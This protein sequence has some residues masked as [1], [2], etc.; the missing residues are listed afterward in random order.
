MREFYLHTER[1][2][3]GHGK[4]N[5]SVVMI[6]FPVVYCILVT[7]FILCHPPQ[8]AQLWALC[9]G[10]DTAGSALYHSKLF[11]AHFIPSLTFE[12][13]WWWQLKVFPCRWMTQLDSLH[14][15]NAAWDCVWK[16]YR[17]TSQGRLFL[18]RLWGVTRCIWIVCKRSYWPQPAAGLEV[19]QMNAI[20]AE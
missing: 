1:V 11:R 7:V 5:V 14:L 13:L 6:G 17:L 3:A 4:I 20:C 16:S 18:S 19:Q 9:A 12:I 8:L 10:H 15:F 2:S